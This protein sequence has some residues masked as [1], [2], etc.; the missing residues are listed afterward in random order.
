MSDA[1]DDRWMSFKLLLEELLQRSSHAQYEIEAA[2]HE[3]IIEGAIPLRERG[4]SS[5]FRWR[6]RFSGKP[7]WPDFKNSDVYEI[8]FYKSIIVVERVLNEKIQQCQELPEINLEDM[9]AKNG[10]KPGE[11]WQAIEDDLLLFI[12]RNFDVDP[13]KILLVDL[14]RW[15]ERWLLDRGY[16]KHSRSKKMPVPS[17]IRLH[18]TEVK[19]RYEASMRRQKER[20]TR[21]DGKRM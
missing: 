1:H 20:P 9:S 11:I 17:T 7:Y 14:E 4:S 19:E 3:G 6:D 15:I 12:D 18:A 13:S 21:I 5:Q 2:L 10:R 16:E 8:G